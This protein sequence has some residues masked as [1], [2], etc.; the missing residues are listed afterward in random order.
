MFQYGLHLEVRLE[1]TAGKAVFTTNHLYRINF[2]PL[3][4]VF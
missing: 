4:T 2:I 3:T 1:L